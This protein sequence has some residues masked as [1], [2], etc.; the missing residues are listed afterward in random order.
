M[1]LWVISVVKKLFRR[2]MLYIIAFIVFGII[3]NWGF[4]LFFGRALW[5]YD[6]PGGVLQ[7]TIFAGW[8]VFALLIVFPLLY[9]FLFKGGYF[10]MIVWMVWHEY[11][12][13]LIQWMVHHSSHMVMKHYNEVKWDVTMLQTKMNSWFDDT[14]FWSKLIINYLQKK[15]PLL[16]KIIDIIWTLDEG[17]FA[18]EDTLKQS[19]NEQLKPYIER[20]D[21]VNEWWVYRILKIVWIFFGQPTSQ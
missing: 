17:S 11:R 7:E 12:D 20:T 14:P 1:D 5:A 13:D 3:I 21:V 8:I 19:I 15:L 9:F 2:V 10:E 18:S 4:L 16:D 6:R